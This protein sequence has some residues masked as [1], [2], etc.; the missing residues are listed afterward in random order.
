MEYYLTRIFDIFTIWTSSSG[1]GN[2]ALALQLSS[3][4][5]I[6]FSVAELT[7][8]ELPPKF[9][10]KSGGGDIERDF[11]LGAE[12]PDCRRATPAGAARPHELL[13]HWSCHLASAPVQLP[14]YTAGAAG[15]RPD[16]FDGGRTVVRQLRRGE[17]GGSPAAQLPK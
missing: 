9:R 16:G 17:L 3:G 1:G 10:R 5:T 4:S 2:S 8:P 13:V 7:P 15:L 12:L 11:T 14:E 6:S